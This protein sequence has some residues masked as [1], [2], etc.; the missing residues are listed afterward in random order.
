MLKGEQRREDKTQVT[1]E[2]SK[3]RRK[4]G[5]IEIYYYIM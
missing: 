2:I 1:N 4:E 5:M 3:G